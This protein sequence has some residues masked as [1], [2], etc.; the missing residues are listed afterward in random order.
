[1]VVNLI[2]ILLSILGLSFLIFIHELG[3]YYMARRVGMRVEVFS[4]GFGKPIV[5]WERDGVKWQI[6]WLLF[7]GYVKIA[8][9]EL[10]KDQNPYEIPD[11]FFGK[12]PLDRIKVAA[13]GPITNIVFAFLIFGVLWMMGGR[14]K[15]FSDYTKKIGWVDPSSDLYASGVRPGD[16]IEAYGDQL[17]RDAKDNIYA[18]MT[19]GERI[20][21]KGFKVDYINQRKT[22]F[23]YSVKIY[24]H[25]NA[26][27][28]GIRTAGIINTANYIIYKDKANDLENPLP[29]GSPLADSGIQPGDRIVWVDGE[30][31]FSL[32]QLNHL[33]NGKTALLTVERG[34]H[35]FLARVPRV[36][37]Q[38]LKIDSN[39]REELAD[40]QFE[41]K[42]GGTKIQNLYT[43]PY[44]LTNDGI[45]ENSLKFIDRE[46]MKEFISDSPY[47][48]LE[49]PLKAG[50]RII[51]I[52]GVPVHYAYDLLN[53]LQ[54]Y[55]VNIIVQRNEKLADPIFWKEADTE[56]DHEIN[57]KD[58]EKI[59]HRIGT[60]NSLNQQGDLFLLNPIIPKTLAQMAVSPEKQEQ[61]QKDLL[62][63]KKIISSDEDPEKRQIAQRLLEQQEKRLLLG[64]PS[65]Q[66]RKVQYNPSPT[67]M[68]VTVSQ[69]IQRT[70]V[71]LLSGALNPKWIVGPIGIVHIVHESS[72]SGVVEALYWLGAISLNLGIL[73]LLPIPV[74]DG[75]TILVSLLEMA[76]GRR[77]HPKTLEKIVLPFAFILICFFIFL[78]Y[79]DIKRLFSGFFG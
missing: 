48:R 29:E 20:R 74:L 25:P 11:G 10:S 46:K 51:A 35:T 60:A 67:E 34:D 7:G 62:E 26:L 45:V 18:P 47:S 22:P 42:L 9:S 17:Y 77:M 40:W 37:T 23:D 76:T 63:Q 55:R 38:E 27:D 43:I 44:N 52:N 32:S 30:L 12:K 36:Q 73:N 5:T 13:M 19:G 78:T 58:L 72:M 69:E 59:I 65:A 71:G 4:I 3:H 57:G 2:Y 24:Q 28:K 15:N 50:D 68:I 41:A 61:Y 64:I 6:C 70:L 75:G 39:F 33:L 66:D 56:F 16:E 8:G 14:E 79:H 21:V 53:Q 54:T 1:M 31:I 49:D